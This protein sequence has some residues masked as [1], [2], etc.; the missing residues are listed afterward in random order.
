MR[1][2]RGKKKKTIEGRDKPLWLDVGFTV[3]I[4]DYQGRETFT[5]IDER[6]G[7]RYNLFESEKRDN[8]GGSVQSFTAA[9]PVPATDKGDVPF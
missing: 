3:L 6:T 5:L 4:G 9:D 7:E 1:I 8:S 2:L